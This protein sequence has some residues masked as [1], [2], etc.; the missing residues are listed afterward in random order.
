MQSYHNCKMAKRIGNFSSQEKL[1]LSELIKTHEI[2][3]SKAYNNTTIEQ[4][5]IAWESIT[6][7]F[8]GNFPE[9][10]P[11]DTKTII[12]L[13]RRMKLQAKVNIDK[14]KKKNMR[15]GTGGGPPGSP[16]TRVEE[17]VL[18]L[19]GDSA[20]PY[21]DEGVYSVAQYNPVDHF[22]TFDIPVIELPN[23]SDGDDKMG[24]TNAVFGSTSTPSTRMSRSS[25]RKSW[26]N[27]EELKIMK[28][29][30]NKQMCIL[31]IQEKKSKLEL[32]LL[33]K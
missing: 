29:M 3:E 22:A 32:Y 27:E 5:K 15:K 9:C 31:D 12:G 1:R 8:N 19:L 30:H 20:N 4:K 28:E 21:D 26:E 7:A 2:V 16:L 6:Q 17:N 18:A 33:E 14:K 11:R 23:E 13:W 25:K 10:P 24:Y